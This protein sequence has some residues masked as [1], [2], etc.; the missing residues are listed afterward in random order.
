MKTTLAAALVAAVVVTPA[1]TSSQ[2]PQAF[3]TGTAA[4]SGVIVDGASDRPIAGATV[5]LGTSLQLAWPTIVVTDAMGRFVFSRLPSGTF[6]LTAAK[7]GYFLNRFGQSEPNVFGI[8]EIVLKDSQWFS[9]ARIGLFRPGAITGRIT[10]ESGEPVVNVPVRAYKRIVAA[11]LPQIAG[12]PLAK[13][14]D[15]GIYR[16]TGLTSGNYMVMVPSVQAAIPA[17]TTLSTYMGMPTDRIFQA[18][19][20]GVRFPDDPAVFVDPSTRLVIGRFAVPPPVDGWMYPPAAFPAGTNL[21]EAQT[22]PLDYGETRSGIDIRLA[23]VRGVRVRG[24]IQGPPESA[25]GGRVLR[26]LATGAESLGIGSETATT[27][28]DVTGAFTFVNVPPGAYTVVASK[29]AMEY[30]FQGVTSLQMVDP[31]GWTSGTITIGNINSASAN[32]QYTLRQVEA[33]APYYARI[34]VVVGRQDL[35]GVVVP[36]VRTATIRGRLEGLITPTSTVSVPIQPAPPPRPFEVQANIVGIP[37]NGDLALGLPSGSAANSLFGVTGFQNGEYILSFQGLRNAIVK[38]IFW[39]GRD[40]TDR[41]FDARDGRDI[42]DVVVTVTTEVSKI[43]GTVHTS[44][45]SPAPSAVVVV[46]P[47]NRS[48]WPR[49]GSSLRFKSQPAAIS[50]DF[51]IG[52]LPAGDYAVIAVSDAQAAGWQE[53][54]FF[55]A[56][57][58]KASKISIGWGEARTVSLTLADVRAR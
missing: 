54:T 40:Y 20:I 7:P 34:N 21:A 56:A 44:A 3:E 14:D 58:L 23:P 25:V 6:R 11:G 4:I 36:M 38:S 50:G 28:A 17:D 19:Q 53:L 18:Q 8:R 32:A 55:A 46:F 22:V 57:M 26:L 31:P 27:L 37:A 47:E 42:D 29:T 10:D 45:G 15:R 43:S 41:P 49:S 13:T 24:I 51:S 2:V 39:Q 9:E 30:S 33:G 1:K 16:L 35:D 5:Q 48:L 52:P 12:G